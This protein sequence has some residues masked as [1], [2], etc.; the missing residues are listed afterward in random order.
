MLALVILAACGDA[1]EHFDRSRTGANE[2]VL[3]FGG[4]P[5]APATIKPVLVGLGLKDI[6]IKP[7]QWRVDGV[8]RPALEITVAYAEWP[9]PTVREE[10]VAAIRGEL[11]SAL[12]KAQWAGNR[13][14]IRSTAP[15]DETR[16]RA[17]IDPHARVVGKM[18]IYQDEATLEFHA[19]P[20]VGGIDTQ[21]E[22]ALE[23]TLPGTDVIV[24][25]TYAV[26]PTR[27]R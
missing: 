24:E 12:T 20:L 16:V 3:S 8:L 22:R 6:E 5:P 19:D 9:P 1:G 10:I 2:V 14:F 15:I 23:A 21:I 7:G 13:I 17:A 4:P 26:G 11:G 18:H 27:R 25:E